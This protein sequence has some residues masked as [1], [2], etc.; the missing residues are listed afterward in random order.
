MLTF[1]S[2]FLFF[3]VIYPVKFCDEINAL[4][5]KYNLDK[6][7]VMSII[8]VESGFNSNAKSKRGAIGLM[9][10]MP[11]TASWVATKMGIEFDENKLFEPDVNIEFGCYYL[12]YLFS[13][14]TDQNVVIAAYNGGEGNARNW[15]D[16]NG[17]LVLDKI[18]MYETKDYV[19]KV[20]AAINIYKNRKI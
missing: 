8:K 2:G 20:N 14:F 1:G 16:E 5:T 18:D 15:L 7:L 9:Q 12:N 11:S 13:K 3:N 17:L 10:I 6:T 19:L 4:S